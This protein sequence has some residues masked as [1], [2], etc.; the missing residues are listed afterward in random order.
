MREA[1]HT[2]DTGPVTVALNQARAEH[3]ATG[4][5]RYVINKDGGVEIVKRRPAKGLG[6]Y[7]MV[8]KGDLC[9]VV[10]GWA[11]AD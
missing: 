3:L 11:K 1:T 6:R 8:D 5:K 4:E 10:P 7:W 2:L 9:M